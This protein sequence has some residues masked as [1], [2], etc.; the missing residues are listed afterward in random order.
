M[1]TLKDLKSQDSVL[2]TAHVICPDAA[3]ILCCP[4]KCYVSDCRGGIVFLQIVHQEQIL[5]IA[6][7]YVGA[8]PS[9]SPG[10]CSDLFSSAGVTQAITVQSWHCDIQ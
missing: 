5:E 8:L 1:E 7:E 4:G 9:V 6:W 10:T 3:A 2:S